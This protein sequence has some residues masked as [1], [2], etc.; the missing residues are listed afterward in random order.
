MI[1]RNLKEEVAKAAHKLYELELT[2]GQDSGDVSLRDPETNLVYICPR[3]NENLAIPNWGVIKAD[4]I[5]VMDLEGN[6]KEDNGI[7]ATVEAPMHL[8]IYKARPEVN[9]IVHSHAEWSSVFAVTG[10]NIPLALA[11]QALFLGGEIICA[12]YGKVGSTQLAENI[13]KALGTEKNCALLRN[14]GAV[15]V[16]K[17]MEEA[18]LNAVFLEKGAKNA[19]F[20]YLLGGLIEIHPDDILDESLIGQI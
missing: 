11:E 15:A 16:G 3:P 4:D 19:L 14:H 7:L 6:I 2:P 13:V 10:R 20:G 1:K 9:A 18:F 5:V 8:Y 12:E 17:D